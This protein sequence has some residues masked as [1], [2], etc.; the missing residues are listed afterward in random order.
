M[1]ETNRALATVFEATANLL[2]GQKANVYRVRAYRRAAEA[3]LQLD[4]D[5]SAVAARGELRLIPGIG[6]DLA[7]RI[8]EF[9]STGTIQAY[10]ELKNPLPPE[11]VA[12]ISL[13][14]LSEP[15]VQQLY[16]R[17]S[18]RTLS[19]LE[20]LVRSHLLR[21]LRGVSASE[22]ELL[23]AIQERQDCAPDP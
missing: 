8:E 6:R 2:A 20:A 22:E 12:W 16:F 19:D 3:I 14:G 10:Q 11:V 13:P 9:L 15:V 5:I 17:L 7:S 21:T 18:I 23:A 1:T 4:E